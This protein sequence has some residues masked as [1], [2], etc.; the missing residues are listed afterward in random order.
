MIVGVVAFLLYQL[1][2]IFLFL[3]P[4]QMLF[5]RRG[6]RQLIV[7]LLA[8][9]GAI[10]IA[11]LVRS[12]RLTGLEARTPLLI[13]DLILPAVFLGGLLAADTDWGVSGVGQLHKCTAAAAVAGLVSVP[14]ILY[15][16]R[17]ESLRMVFTDQLERVAQALTRS[18]DEVPGGERTL[19]GAFGDAEALIGFFAGVLLRNY[20]FMF[21]VMLAGS[22]WFG[23]ALGNRT[24]GRAVRR[25][26]GFRAP[27]WY[28][29]PLIS[30]WAVVLLDLIT[31]VGLL[32]YF[33]WNLGLV[34]LF[35]FGMQAVGIIQHLLDRRNVS[36][37]IRF[38]IVAS[39]C[40]ALFWPGLNLVVI[41]G[42]PG[43][44]VSEIWIKYREPKEE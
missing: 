3:L 27:D 14:I 23:N 22:L 20:V 34:M 42:L 32:K 29:W 28:V 13:I 8:V 24:S 37:G 16:T 10:A 41:V 35:T 40:I 15:I 38:V 17:N 7:A 36:R 5:V 21:F 1:N 18:S 39:M 11:A 31:D 26:A 30:G 4:L 33:G 6:R 12:A 19:F 44:G 43:F 9:T 25:L 2:M